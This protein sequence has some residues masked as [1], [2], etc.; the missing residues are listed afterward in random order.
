MRLV[1]TFLFRAIV[2]G[3]SKGCGYCKSRILYGYQK[4]TR[5]GSGLLQL[6]PDLVPDQMLKNW[7][8]SNF[9]V[10]NLLFFVFDLCAISITS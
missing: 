6:E 5:T 4:Y 1:F 8:I 10:L 2:L 9:I 7:H 3:R